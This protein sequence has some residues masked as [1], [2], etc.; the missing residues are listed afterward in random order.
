MGD[1]V[2]VEDALPGRADDGVT[3]RAGIVPFQSTGQAKVRDAR[4]RAVGG[5]QNVLRF[6]VAVQ[7]RP[8]MGVGDPRGDLTEHLD[9]SFQLVDCFLA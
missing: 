1:A 3:H 9:G 5:D 8:L 4:I 2:S 7:H 6:D